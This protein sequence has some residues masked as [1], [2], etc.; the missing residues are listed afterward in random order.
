MTLSECCSNADRG[1]FHML[2][3]HPVIHSVMTLG[4]RNKWTVSH[5]QDSVRLNNLTEKY[6]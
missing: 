3:E 4:G 6:C 5:L 2:Q 1:S